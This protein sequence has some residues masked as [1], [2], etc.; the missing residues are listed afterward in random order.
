MMLQK[1]PLTMILH[2]YD[3]SPYSEM[4]RLMLGYSEIAWHSA[5][6]L[7]YPPRPTVDPLVGGYRRIPIAQI[8]SDIFCD[9]RI[10]A[11]EIARLSERPELSIDS[12]ESSA[13]AF[14][15]KTNGETFFPIVNTA[16]P[17]ALLTMLVT[18]YWPWQI[19]RLIRDRGGV[20]KTSNMPRLKKKEMIGNINAF[21]QELESKLQDNNYL[22]GDSPCVADFAAYHVIWFA[23]L[24]RSASFLGNYPLTKQW[25][26]RMKSIGHG[27]SQKISRQSVFQGA[28]L[29]EPRALEQHLLQ[30]RDINKT[31]TISPS[32]YARD[33]VTGTL[34]GADDS[35]LIIARESDQLG[36]LHV[37]FPVEGY[38]TRIHQ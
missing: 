1:I 37:H 2:N 19:L 28:K 24:T 30:H 3:I 27:K 15:I 9:T 13:A 7:P 6:S 34:V 31:I 26:E 17:R 18:R 22:F 14:A 16:E 32:D 38:D 23:D 29:S 11:A 33:S 20:A 25:H 36:T 8:E 21:R 4:I 10:I 5:I 35:R 12:C